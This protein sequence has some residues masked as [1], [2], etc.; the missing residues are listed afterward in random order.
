MID[1]DYFWMKGYRIVEYKNSKYGV[2]RYANKNGTDKLFVIDTADLDLVLEK[3][4]SW[5]V[6]DGHIG[7]TDVVDRSVHR[8]YLHDMI[9]KKQTGFN[10]HHINN[11]ARDLRTAN[12]TLKSTLKP[13]KRHIY[14]PPNSGISVKDIPQDVYY[15]EP[16]GG[17]GEMFII[18][19]KDGDKR[20]IWKS[21]S[22]DASLK[23]K[24]AE[25]KTK[26]AEITNNGIDPDKLVKQFNGII[27]ESGYK[28][29]K[30]NLVKR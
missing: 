20:K 8:Y 28:C 13:K 15:C 24:L 7:F 17:Q 23:D 2:C 18:D 1:C 14:L 29:A 5:C 30:K 21:S 12:L 6:I 27:T 9:L 10:V 16:R 22:G 3:W 19:I 11:T 26:L 4:D 25:I